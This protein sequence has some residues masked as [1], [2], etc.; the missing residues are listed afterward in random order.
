MV[1]SIINHNCRAMILIS[2]FT[3]SMV[4]RVVMYLICHKKQF[5]ISTPSSV[6]SPQPMSTIRRKRTKQHE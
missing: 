1:I 2:R 4:M 5:L 6:S 3:M